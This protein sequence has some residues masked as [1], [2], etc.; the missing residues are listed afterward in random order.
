[1]AVLVVNLMMAAFKRKLVTVDTVVK[2]INEAMEAVIA[3]RT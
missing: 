2:A 3:D 1:M